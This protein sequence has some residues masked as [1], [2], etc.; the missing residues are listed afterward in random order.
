MDQANGIIDESLFIPILGSQENGQINHVT[1]RQ[2][3]GRLEATRSVAYYVFNSV[4][5]DRYKVGIPQAGQ[6]GF[7]PVSFLDAARTAVEASLEW[8]SQAL[9][10]I[11]AD[12]LQLGFEKIGYSRAQI[13]KSTFLVVDEAVAS[14]EL[15]QRKATKAQEKL[16]EASAEL[17][18]AKSLLLSE[19]DPSNRTV[20]EAKRAV[21]RADE[22]LNR[23]LR[24]LN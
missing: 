18:L 8:D 21:G 10:A 2:V 19:P 17:A 12:N 20:R 15:K 13:E 14:G 24:K 3:G 6:M 9:D 11:D 16:A 4:L 5:P 23:A 22:A 1:G 7:N